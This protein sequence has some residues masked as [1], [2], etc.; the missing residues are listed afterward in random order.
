MRGV[1]D[2]SARAR[3]GLPDRLA[4]AGIGLLLLLLLLSLPMGSSGPV[5]AAVP[6][7]LPPTEGR[8]FLPALAVAPV[9]PGG[10]T[11]LL[12][13]VADPLDGPLTNLTVT[14]SFYAFN[15]FPGTGTEPLP[16]T[17]PVLSVGGGNPSGSVTVALGTLGAGATNASAPVDVAAP[18]GTPSGTYALRD[19]IGFD[20][21][22]IAYRLASIGNF[23]P[24]L[25]HN[26]TVL[27]NGTPTLNLTR[28]GVAGVIPET[29]VLV[30]SSAALD[31]ALYAT[32]GAA[33]VLALAGA[34]VALRRRGP[35]SRSGARGPPPRE[36]QAPTAFG[37]N[38]SSEG[39]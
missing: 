8:S 34:Y 24:A 36:S 31:T 21:A 27:P 10:S 19:S 14:F 2:R 13:S 1:A 18:P 11:P 33:G 32:L 35:A 20:L 6:A 9:V 16:A 7:P 23:P 38:R 22:G 39:D 26:A 3:P 15:P 25:W 4:A 30:Q 37:N 12:F 17:A 29:A 5:A 28:L